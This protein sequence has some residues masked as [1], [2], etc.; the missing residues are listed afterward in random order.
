MCASNARYLGA[1]VR[2]LPGAE[3]TRDVADISKSIA[4][5][6]TCGDRGP[7]SAGAVDDRRF[8][9]VQLVQA[10]RKLS[11]PGWTAFGMVPA[12]TSPSCRTSTICKSDSSAT[13]SSNAFAVN[14][15]AIWT[16]SDA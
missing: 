13:R 15:E 12:A 10:G 9:G 6:R 2:V 5:Q 1:L 7:V 8:G 4:P 3:P 11:R 14:R 16:S